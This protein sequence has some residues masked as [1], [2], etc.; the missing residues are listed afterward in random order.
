[1]I[2]G[3]DMNATHIRVWTP[4]GQVTFRLP[5]GRR[6]TMWTALQAVPTP[7]PRARRPTK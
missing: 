5:R 7:R 6:P 3:V 1:M 2:R 4:G